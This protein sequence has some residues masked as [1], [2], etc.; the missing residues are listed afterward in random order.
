MSQSVS[1]SPCRASVPPP[2]AGEDGSEKISPAIKY[3]SH[4]QIFHLS[5]VRT[6]G[7][8]DG[9]LLPPTFAIGVHVHQRRGKTFGQCRAFVSCLPAATNGDIG[10]GGCDVLIRADRKS[11]VRQCLGFCTADF[12]PVWPMNQQ[13]KNSNIAKLETSHQLWSSSTTTARRG[14]WRGQH[15]GFGL[16]FANDETA[17]FS[18]DDQR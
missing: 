15:V 5:S 4:S 13:K 8:T 18:V 16:L 2:V 6:E 3:L 9:A 17:H 1:Q 11:Q 12:S 14:L 10:G 7:R